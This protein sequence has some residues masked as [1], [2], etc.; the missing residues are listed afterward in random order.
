MKFY[1][2]LISEQEKKI[3]WASTSEFCS[4]R[5]GKPGHG[6][7]RR[8][9]SLKFFQ[10]RSWPR[11][12][13]LSREPQSSSTSISTIQALPPLSLSRFFFVFL[14]DM[15]SWLQSYLP[16]L[17]SNVKS[18]L[19]NSNNRHS[20]TSGIYDLLRNKWKIKREY[21]TNTNIFICFTRVFAR[22]VQTFFLQY[23]AMKRRGVNR[24]LERT[25][26]IWSGG[27]LT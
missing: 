2:E 7:Y 9:A 26:S 21:V 15:L 5:Y 23:A 8:W 25:R 24:R 3:S 20:K 17:L 13:Y 19:W 16:E 27:P 11:V 22:W 14:L 12:L 6:C 18:S 1:T 10:R 4:V